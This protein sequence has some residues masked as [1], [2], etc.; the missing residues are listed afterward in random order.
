MAALPGLGA[1]VERG[2]SARH[3]YPPCIST[4]KFLLT[5]L[6]MQ[7]NTLTLTRVTLKLFLVPH[8]PRQPSNPKK[9]CVTD[10]HVPSLYHGALHALGSVTVLT[11]PGTGQGS[12]MQAFPEIPFP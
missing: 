10:S 9:R 7:A 2:A 4:P 6:T 11:L 3:G 12:A 5:I 1:L 8:L